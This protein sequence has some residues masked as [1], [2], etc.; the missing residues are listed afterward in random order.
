M[1]QRQVNELIDGSK[2]DGGMDEFMDGR[3]MN[4]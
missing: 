2:M 4:E 3:W 1:D